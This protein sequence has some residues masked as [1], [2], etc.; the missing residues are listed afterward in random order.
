MLVMIMLTYLLVVIAFGL[1]SEYPLY[2]LHFEMYCD[3]DELLHGSRHQT[4]GLIIFWPM[5]CRVTKLGSVC[6]VS[7]SSFLLSVF[8]VFH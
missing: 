8:H 1:K 2:L 7:Y 6:L 4:V 3:L 5:S